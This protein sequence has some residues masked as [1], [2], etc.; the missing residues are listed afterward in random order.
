[1]AVSMHKTNSTTHPGEV[2]LRNKQP[3]W[4][5]QQIKA[6]EAHAAA[7]GRATREEAAA[8]HHAILGRIAE[9]EDFME[10]ADAASH[11]HAIRPDLLQPR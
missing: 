6:N 7:V 2:L 5:Q 8:N 3:W 9:L 11:R 10:Q 1:M 4:T